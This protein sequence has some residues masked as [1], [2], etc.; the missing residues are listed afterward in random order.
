MLC[1][2]V[3][4]CTL[5]HCEVQNCTRADMCNQEPCQVHMCAIVWRQY[6]CQVQLCAI[7]AACQCN[8]VQFQK[9]CQVQKCAV[10][11][12]CVQ[13]CIMCNAAQSCIILNLAQ[14]MQWQYLVDKSR[15]TGRICQVKIAQHCIYL[16]VISFRNSWHMVCSILWC[17]RAL[18]PDTKNRN[19]AQNRA[20]CSLEPSRDA[21]Q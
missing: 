21:G 15:Q 2:T 20:Y 10:M 19:P 18:H 3:K 4:S 8:C 1:I 11:C 17:S 5:L 12:N 6:A 7:Q 16:R 14:S 9:L 13:L